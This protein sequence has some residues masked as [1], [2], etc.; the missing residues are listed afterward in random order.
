MA[1]PK[2]ALKVKKAKRYRAWAVVSKNGTPLCVCFNLSSFEYYSGDRI[3][4]CTV[5]VD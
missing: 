3:R 2:K 1:K 5:T 4:R